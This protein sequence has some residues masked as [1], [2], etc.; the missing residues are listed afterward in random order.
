MWSGDIFNCEI[1]YSTG[2]RNKTIQLDL[3]C[4]CNTILQTG[5]YIVIKTT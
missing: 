4:Y 2:L 1:V 3:V 5:T